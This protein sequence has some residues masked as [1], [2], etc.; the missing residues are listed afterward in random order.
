MSYSFE[1]QKHLLE[2]QVK[3]EEAKT[4]KAEADV[5]M[6][7]QRPDVS[8]VSSALSFDV[9][10]KLIPTFDASEPDLLF[11]IFIFLF[12]FFIVFRAPCPGTL[13]ASR[14]D[15]CPY[16]TLVF[17]PCSLCSLGLSWRQ[18]ECERGYF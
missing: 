15:D 5:T 16:S 13:V 1:K 14:V 6:L 8:H 17:W 10:R 3:R 9:A 4:R 18:Q 11:F 2:V 12:F 7:T